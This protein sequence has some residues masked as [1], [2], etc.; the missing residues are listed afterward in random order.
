MSTDA[1]VVSEQ[2]P[3]VDLMTDVIVVGSGPGA[4][5][6]AIEARLAGWEVIV[7]E[8]TGTLGGPEAERSG[9][10]WLPGRGIVGDDY[11]SARDYFDRVV[12]NFDAASPPGRRMAC[13]NNTDELAAW[14]TGL[15]V[16]LTATDLPDHH[17]LPG[18]RASGRVWAPRGFDASVI[19]QLADQ[20]P[21]VRSVARAQNVVGRSV[22][23]LT[24]IGGR[25]VSGGSAVVAALLAA[26]QRLQAMIWWNA[27]PRRLLVAGD[28]VQGVVLERAGRAVRLYAGHGVILAQGGFEGDPATRREYLPSSPRVSRTIGPRR[29]E[30]AR[31]INWALEHDLQLAGLDRLW[32][33]PGL[34]DPAGATWDASEALAAPHGILVGLDGQRFVDETGDQ[35]AIC[36]GL[37]ARG[38]EGA[39][40]VIDAEHRRRVRLG[41]F[42]PGRL[43]NTPERESMVVTARTL[44]ELAWKTGIDAAG[45]E[46]S[47]AR[48]DSFAEQGRDEDHHRGESGLSRARSEQTSG[49]RRGGVV[50]TAL[51]RRT[52]RP[53]NPALGALSKGP[54]HAVRVVVGDRG[55]KGGLVTD[56]QARVLR[57]DGTVMD[58]LWA[59]GSASA[60]VCGDGDPAPGAALTEAL[61]FGRLAGRSVR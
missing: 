44:P 22:A 52:N 54:F 27:A 33:V 12:G 34:W 1:L 57:A 37:A 13:L 24:S 55:T 11:A 9:L 42:A 46:A 25:R 48:F 6:A 2:A 19:G 10:M 35:A 50:S 61:V 49:V 28:R 32:T 18:W 26:C 16:E 15:G 53:A 45:L 8:P 3:A 14:L 30:G 43:P 40:L 4:L 59:V 58:G 38:E 41:P 36:R 7:A 29:S 60:S 39:W 17:E 51:E 31:I 56:E 5:A 47:V 23:T 20:L 21:G